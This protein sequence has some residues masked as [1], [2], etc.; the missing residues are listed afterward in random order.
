MYADGCA[1]P[2]ARASLN[3][4]PDPVSERHG[5]F[6]TVRRKVR[7]VGVG[8]FMMHR[9]GFRLVL[10]L[11]FASVHISLI[12]YTNQRQTCNYRLVV[13]QEEPVGTWQPEPKPL[14]TAQKLSL[15]LN[16][17]SLF[18]AIPFLLILRHETDMGMLYAALPFVPIT[19]YAIGRWID[20]MLGLVRKRWRLP[21]SLSGFVSFL[22]TV[23]LVLSA[24]TVT[25]L[26]HHRRPDTYWVGT[27]L[28]LW[29]GL[30]LV[31]SL[32]SFYRRPR[33]LM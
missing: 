25:P 2:S 5:D 13:H 21:R 1:A 28:I 10:P 7:S 23:L 30:L 26:N 19:W 32:S 3:Y 24:C 18:L 16:L 27:A 14:T 6:S 15:I 4:T 33:Q 11:V 20:G 8:I 31:M 22:A 12:V 29:S 17:P 9:V